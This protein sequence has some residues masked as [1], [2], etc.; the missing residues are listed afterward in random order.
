MFG[1]RMDWRRLV[2]RDEPWA[3]ACFLAIA[4]KATIMLWPPRS[5]PLAT[6]AAGDDRL[7][8]ND[9]KSKSRC[10]TVNP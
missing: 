9:E 8:E 3:K 4:L 7:Q 1:R 2:P 5:P 6:D 10:K